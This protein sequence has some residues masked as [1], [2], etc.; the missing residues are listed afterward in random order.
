MRKYIPDSSFSLHIHRDDK[1]LFDYQREM[2]GNLYTAWEQATSV[3]CQMPTGTGKTYLLVSVVKDFVHTW[4]RPVWIVA[5]RV[6][7]IEQISCTLTRYGLP[8]GK[9][10]G[11]DPFTQEQIQV[12]SIQTLSSLLESGSG[13]WMRN[14]NIKVKKLEPPGLLVIDEAHHSPANSYRRLWQCFPDVYKLGVTAT[15]CRLGREGFAALFERLLTSWPIT[16][17]IE[18][19]RLALFDYLSVSLHS[20]LQQRVDSLVKR[21][22]DGDYSRKEMG[23]VMDCPEAI[24][25]LY[26]AYRQYAFGKKGIIYAVNRRHSRHIYEYYSSQ[27]VSIASIDSRTPARER[28]DHVERYRNGEIDVIVNVDIF[29]E[30]FDCPEVEFIQL[31]RPTLSLAKYLQQVGRGLRVHPDKVKTLILDQ[32]GLY[33]LFGLPTDKHDWMGMFLGKLSG[34]GK[35]VSEREEWLLRQAEQSVKLSG[36]D[37]LVVIQ[38]SDEILRQAFNRRAEVEPYEEK[39]L[40]GLKKGS[41]VILPPVYAHI[42]PFVGKYAVFTLGTG[43]CGLLTRSGHVLPLP[44][45]LTIELLPDEFAYIEESPLVRYYLDLKSFVKFPGLPTVFRLEFLE[46]SCF[47]N[48]YILRTRKLNQSYMTGFSAEEMTLEGDIFYHS[49]VFIHRAFPDKIFMYDGQDA[50]N[51]L[52]LADETNDLYL[53]QPGELPVP[54][55]KKSRFAKR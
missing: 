47:R 52:I 48:R 18:E 27:G 51:R 42:D 41:Q 26:Q 31:A 10:V 44:K 19:G 54:T 39:G 3:L 50:K 2:K 13:V 16:R 40:Y 22:S 8:H 23:A 32:V 9:I 29:S 43:R 4:N 24:V 46:F 25:Q 53:Y 11:G 38:G 7:L 49:F 17:F 5:H 6:E 33:R 1:E 36:E 55:G 21:G 14:E 12:A 30:G 28:A 35:R 34:K 37:D 15:P 45:C 20:D